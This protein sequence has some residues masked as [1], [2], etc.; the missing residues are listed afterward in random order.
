[1]QGAVLL[2]SSERVGRRL[3][4]RDLSIYHSVR[5]SSSADFLDLESAD[6]IAR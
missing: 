4:R 3:Q 5:I 1:V 2:E 6:D